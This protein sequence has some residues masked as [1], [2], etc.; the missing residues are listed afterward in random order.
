M[1]V[2]EERGADGQVLV[3]IVPDLLDE[4]MGRIREE[5]FYYGDTI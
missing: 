4:I 2:D 3:G 5:Y 1:W